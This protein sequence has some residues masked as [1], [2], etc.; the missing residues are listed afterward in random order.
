LEKEKQR[1]NIFVSAWSTSLQ[2]L[3]DRLRYTSSNTLVTGHIQL[4]SPSKMA[5]PN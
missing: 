1:C 4:L 5:N 3:K 2:M